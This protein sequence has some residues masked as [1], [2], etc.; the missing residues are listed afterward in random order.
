MN[1]WKAG[2]PTRTVPTQRIIRAHHGGSREKCNKQEP[3]GRVTP[4]SSCFTICFIGLI[5]G[6]VQFFGKLI[7]VAVAHMTADVRGE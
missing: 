3:T 1:L 6:F 5:V 2:V 4:V 7:Y